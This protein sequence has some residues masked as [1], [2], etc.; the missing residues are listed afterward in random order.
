VAAPL[1]ALDRLLSN[2]R[3]QQARGAFYGAALQRLWPR[4]QWRSGV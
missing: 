4:C 3:L 1:K 2:R